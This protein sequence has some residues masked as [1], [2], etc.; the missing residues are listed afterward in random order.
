MMR[1]LCAPALFAVA[2]ANQLDVF[3]PHYTPPAECAHGCASW[4]ALPHLNKTQMAGMWQKG[5]VPAE[6][7]NTCS[8]PGAVVSSAT[9]GP[10]TASAG[11][12]C[13][14]AEPAQLDGT[15]K[16]PS[17]PTAAAHYCT[18]NRGVPEQIN[19]QYAS[20]DTVRSQGNSRVF[21]V[22][23]ASFL[24]SFWAGNGAGR[25]GFRHLRGRPPGL[26]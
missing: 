9:G 18:P 10:E 12:F 3:F 26:R 13:Y 4:D 11:A 15:P 23:F 14:C 19:L 7:S 8:I 6:A 24:G 21:S 1:L 17:K 20:A 25:R 16:K 5:A 22:R 2:G